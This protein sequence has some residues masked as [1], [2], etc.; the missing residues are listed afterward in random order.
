MELTLISLIVAHEK[1]RGIGFEQ[2]IPWFIPGE[3][4][5]VAQTTKKT[6][7][8][9]KINALIMGRNTWYSLPVSRRPLIGRLNIVISGTEI[10]PHDDVLTFKSL[11][12]AIAYVSSS[13]EIDTGFIFGGA[14]LYNEAL[15]KG[16]VDEALISEVQLECESDTFFP[17]IPEYLAKSST[18]LEIYCDIEVIRT[19]YK[20][21]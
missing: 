2:K 19:V 6:Q 20:R 16:Y 17:E 21:K 4:R 7:V 12:A 18:E 8:E 13:E 1:K 15:G 3:L 14:S 9:G 11:D 5:W 10:I